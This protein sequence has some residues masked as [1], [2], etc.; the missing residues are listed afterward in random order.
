MGEIRKWNEHAGEVVDAR[1][2]FEVIACVHCGFRHVVPLPT[3]A[4]LR[5][6]YAHD[7]YVE[8]KPMYVEEAT[9]DRPWWHLAYTRRYATLESFLDGRVGRLLDVGS[10]PGYF[11][12]TGGDRGWS[13]VGIEPSTRAWE[14]STSLGLQVHNRPFDATVRDALGVFDVVHLSEVLEHLRD[15]AEAVRLARDMLVPGGVLCVAVPNDYN[16]LQRA[17]R[18]VVGLEPWW[19]APPHHLNYFDFDSLEALV[20]NCGLQVLRRETSFP[21]EL[22]LLMGDVY[23]GDAVLGRS[24]H[25]RRKSL[26]MRLAEAGLY[27]LWMEWLEAAAERG[28]GRH[29]IVYA[30][31]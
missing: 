26:E 19:V 25:G 14:H 29:A 21:M 24:C 12:H 8:D 5:D 15:P 23:I 7:Y 28:L 11:L 4:E 3:E 9:E 1:G 30:R 27:D 6:I 16:P 13:V 22:F 2:G 18:D 17:A 31:R 20:R 10:G